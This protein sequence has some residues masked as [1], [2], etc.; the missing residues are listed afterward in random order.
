MKILISLLLISTSI[1]SQI[2]NQLDDKG[3]KQGLWK[4]QYVDSKRPRYEGVFDN[5]K[6]KGVFK[7]FDDTAENTIIAT[8][9]FNDIDNSCITIF[10]NQKGNKVS[11]GKV[12]NK[13]FEGLWIYYHENS[14]KIMTS[15]FYNNGKLEDIK[16]VFYPSGKIAQETSYKNGLKEG[17]DKHYAENGT[18]IEESIYKKNEFDGP[19]IFRSPSNIVVAKGVFVKGKKIGIWEFNTNGKKTKENYNYQ[20]KRKFAKRTNAKKD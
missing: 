9:E 8:R 12:K 14:K 11:E 20:S 13:K 2:T 16:K 17:L 3:N 6:E 19:A 7:F 1:F 15:E 18:V 5:G 4:G 10:Y